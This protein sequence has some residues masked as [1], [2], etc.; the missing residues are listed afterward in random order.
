M[1]RFSWMLEASLLTVGVG[2]SEKHCLKLAFTNKSPN[3]S[4]SWQRS[5]RSFLTVWELPSVFSPFVCDTG[6]E[7]R[8]P[9]QAYS[10]NELHIQS[11]ASAL[12]FWTIYFETGS[13]YVAQT[14][15]NLPNLHKAILEMTSVYSEIK[16]GY[17]LFHELF[18]V[19]KARE[20]IVSLLTLLWKTE[21]PIAS[22]Y[23]S[24]CAVHYRKRMALLRTP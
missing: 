20:T 11:L 18:W 15:L 17:G 12:I 23:H 4:P 8:G 14:G 3:L 24:Y 2:F 6:P 19:Q 10:T 22:C 21:T 16:S 1:L 9:N 5:L 13:H 7:P